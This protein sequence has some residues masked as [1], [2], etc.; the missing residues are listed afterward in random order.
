LRLRDQA[1]GFPLNRPWN[2]VER[3]RGDDDGSGGSDLVAKRKKTSLRIGDDHSPPLTCAHY[4]R[5][6]DWINEAEKASGLNGTKE[7]D[8]GGAKETAR[9]QNSALDFFGL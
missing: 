7:T 1:D 8:D 5:G 9:K 3:K 4:A 2:E 6:E